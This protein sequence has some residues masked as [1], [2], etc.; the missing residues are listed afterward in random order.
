MMGGRAYY[1][2]VCDGEAEWVVTRRGD[3]VTRWSCTPDLGATMFDFG[4]RGEVSEFVVKA[5]AAGVA[6]QIEE[7]LGR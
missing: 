7:V 1:C 5:S 3:A 4:R 2:H 6:F